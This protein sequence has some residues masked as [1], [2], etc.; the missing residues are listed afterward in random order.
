M[1]P[2]LIFYSLLSYSKELV[3][4]PIH[5]MLHILMTKVHGQDVWPKRVCLFVLPIA[6]IGHYPEVISIRKKSQFLQSHSKKDISH[7]KK[8][9]SHSKKDISHSKKDILT[10]EKKLQY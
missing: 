8:D 5:R 10:E 7:S 1:M 6:R 3:V 4:S 2:F 9:I